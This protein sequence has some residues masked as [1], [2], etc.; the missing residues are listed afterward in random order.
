MMD[1][2]AQENFGNPQLESDKRQYIEFTFD[3]SHG[4]ISDYWE[5]CFRGINKAN[6]VIGNEAA[7]NEIPDSFISQEKKKKYIAEA[8]FL[9][10]LYY[11]FLT[12][13]FGDV[14]LI[15]TIP[16]GPA[17]VPMSPQSDVYAQI[18]QDLRDA[19]QDLLVS[20]DNGRAYKNA[21]IAL[22]GKVLLFQNDHA[23]ALEQFNQLYGQF[24]LE[25]DYFDNFKIETEHGKESIFEIEYEKA[26]GSGAVWNSSVSGAGPNE[27]SF[28][29]QEYGFLNWWNVNPSE[30]LLDEF[31]AGDKRYAG[32]F[33][34]EG[35]M[36]AGGTATV[37]AD[38]LNPGPGPVRAVWKKYQNYY[39]D[40]TEST[41][42]EINFKY[43]RYADVL[44]MLAECEN[45][46]SD[47]AKAI[48]YINEVRSRAGLADLASGLTKDQ[49]FDAI[50]H[51]RK[52]EFPGEQI[53]FN[54]IIRW[55]NAATELSGSNFQAGIHE[56][57]PIP[58]RE[59]QSNEA[60]SPEDQN[61]GY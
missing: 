31:E 16:E 4:P 8:K 20:E 53:R 51:E 37:T 25:E 28:R 44:L 7:I 39:K 17:G 49:V 55:G 23:G 14:P 34:S 33:Y 40:L 32:N 21:A 1:G 30:D 56:L 57:L 43:L 15:T 10:G 58:D 46:L 24:A 11:F 61:P 59:I 42:S 2:L 45:E 6:F 47:Q 50:V 38:N 12:T 5:S 60:L 29:G 19:S 52:V 22:L 54:D 18:V 36:Y 3:S 9:R 26:L 35:D 27:T 13:R 48:G 41:E